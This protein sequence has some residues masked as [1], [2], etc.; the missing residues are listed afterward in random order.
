MGKYYFETRD[1]VIIAVISALGGVSS[2]YIGYL[3]NLINRFL[4]VPFGAG[5]ILA[6][7]HIFWIILGYGLTKK[8][9]TGVMIGVLKAFVELFS[10]GKLGIFVL[11]LSA[12]QGV[13]VDLVFLLSGKRNFISYIVA[14]GIATGVNVFIF[15]LFFASYN[16]VTFFFLI[17]CIAFFSGVIFAGYFSY[18]VLEIL[19]G[20]EK[21]YGV[22]KAVTIGFAT[23]LLFGGIYYYAGIYTLGE[24]I[25]VSGTCENPYDFTYDDLKSFEKT[26]KT[27]MIGQYKYEEEKEYEG[28]PLL[29]IIEKA[30]P[31]GEKIEVV[32]NDGYAVIFDLEKLNEDIVLTEERRLI[33]KGFDGSY[34]V[35]DV[36]EIRIE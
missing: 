28:I 20:K 2:T 9:G 27:E 7:L 5:Q 13:L 32:G 36:V 6:G 11:V 29:K 33:A 1:L 31:K 22:K 21:K 14:G 30:V 10:G 23:A 17:S 15:Q 4:G 19:E 24:K 16:A 25:S 26:V 12:T 18:S 3:G 34:W 35:Q 8:R